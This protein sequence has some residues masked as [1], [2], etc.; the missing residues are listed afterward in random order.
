MADGSLQ[1]DTKSEDN[2]LDRM[3]AELVANDIQIYKAYKS[4]DG[5]IHIQICG[6]PTGKINV[7]DINEQDVDKAQ[8]MGFELIA[9]GELQ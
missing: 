4:N 5:L 1:C 3:Q 7:F 9:Q 6:S 8:A 2:S